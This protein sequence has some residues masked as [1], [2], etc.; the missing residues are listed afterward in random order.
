MLE[1]K[2]DSNDKYENNYSFEQLVERQIKLASCN[3]IEIIQDLINNSIKENKY[4]ILK[5]ANQEFL[6]ILFQL[7]NAFDNSDIP[8]NVSLNKI[9]NSDE[10]IKKNMKDLNDE[11]KILRKENEELANE[12]KALKEKINNV[13]L[14]VPGEHS[15]WDKKC[16]YCNS[17]DIKKKFA[18]WCASWHSGVSGNYAKY[19]L[20]HFCNTCKKRFFAPDNG[21]WT[22]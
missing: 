1:N 14:F 2:V 18:L 21:G 11:V 8:L 16:P 6:N 9:T 4:S 22:D 13:V 15:Q 20:H 7:K 5:N 17:S 3:N 19:Y 10:L 12:V